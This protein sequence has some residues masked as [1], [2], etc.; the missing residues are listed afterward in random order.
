MI[1]QEW[2]QEGIHC[3]LQQDP[4]QALLVVETQGDWQLVQ[5]SAEGNGFWLFFKRPADAQRPEAL[6]AGSDSA[7]SQKAVAKLE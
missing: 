4:S 7:T 1:R 3:T 6:Q 5:A 2:E